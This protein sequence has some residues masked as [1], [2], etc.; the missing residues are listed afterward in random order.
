MPVYL[1][2]ESLVFPHPEYAEPSGL[3]A[4]GG[5]LGVERLLLAYRKGI[6]PWYSEGDPIMWFSPDPRLVLKLP[7]LY[8]SRKLR[9]VIRSNMFEV[10][11]DTS[12]PEIITLCSRTDRKGQDG[13]WITG[14]MIDAYIGLH[15]EG[16][17][18]SVETFYEGRLAGG[19]YGV[20]LGGA[21]FGESMFHMVSDASKV[22]LY[23]LVDRLKKW[24]FDFIDSQVP[25]NHM[26]RMGGRE[27]DRGSFLVM[28]GDALKKETKK[29]SWE[30][31]ISPKRD[32]L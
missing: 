7:D 30:Y 8:V 25:N 9:K 2:N 4:V 22:A 32:R 23:H 14:D 26:K 27:I 16:Y 19:L 29:G 3:L 18:H 5:D 10:R 28:L 11:F 20:S 17:A 15:R 6:F 31:E 12:F 1:L 21:F 24:D 13:T